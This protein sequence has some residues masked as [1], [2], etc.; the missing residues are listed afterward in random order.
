[1]RSRLA[2]LAALSCLLLAAPAGAAELVTIETPSANVAGELRANV[3]LPDGYDGVQEFPV[4]YLLHGAGEGYASWALPEKG[5]ILQTAAGLDAIVVMPEGSA[6]GFYSNWWN[7]GLRADPGWERYHLDELIPLVEE[8]FRVRDGRRWHAIAGFSMGGFGTS[9]YAAQRPGYFGTAVPMSA[10][11]SIR[12]PQ[13]LLGFEPVTGANYDRVW[14]PVTGAYAEGHDPI[15]LVENLEHSRL[16]VATGNG[17]PR[18]GVPATPTAL[19]SGVLELE[20]FTQNLE[21]A[22]TAER[23]GAEVT[24]DHHL[25][26]HDW[27]YWRED[28][29]SAIR[30][31]LFGEVPEAPGSWRYETVAQTGAMWDLRFA[32]AE[33]P[34]EVARFARGGGRLAAGGSGTVT[35]DGGPG[36]SFTASLP[37]DR[38]CSG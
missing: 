14:G 28:L 25:G 23:E 32:F 21:F 31:G 10:L 20:L 3:L 26:V 12:R 1:M 16:Y 2:I 9:F 13:I 22:M 33:P 34:A 5:D 35:I 11:V 36:C 19:V 17:V 15:A 18:P 29:Q 37:F 8:R 4:L 6:N 30:W 27:P 38:A 24:F 7:G